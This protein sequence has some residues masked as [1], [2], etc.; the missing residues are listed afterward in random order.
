METSR[1]M[2]RERRRIWGDSTAV[3]FSARA[4]GRTARAAGRTA[5]AA[6]RTARAAP[7]PSPLPAANPQPPAGRG[8]TR[9][10]P[11]TRSA[12]LTQTESPLPAGGVG[13]GGGERVRVRGGSRDDGGTELRIENWE[14]RTD[15]VSPAKPI[16]N[17]QFSILNSVLPTSAPVSPSPPEPP[18]PGRRS[19]PL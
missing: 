13:V 12:Q 2:A 8:D 1:R 15:A 11:L 3:A 19:G 4:A 14:L 5:R 7:H 17:P 18:R 6:G 9:V 10:V 16:L